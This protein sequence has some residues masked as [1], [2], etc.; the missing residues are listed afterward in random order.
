MNS[1]RWKRRACSEA[2]ILTVNPALYE[3]ALIPESDARLFVETHHYSASYPAARCRVGLYKARQ[4]WYGLPELV[5][6]AVFSV[7]CTQAVV[8][9]YAP[10]LA[11]NEGV[12]LGRFVLLD[13]EPAN[14]ETWFLARAFKLLKAALPQVRVIVSY[15]DPMPRVTLDGREVKPGHYGG[16]YH[17]SS[18]PALGRSSRRTLTLAPDATVIS[19]RGLSKIRLGEVGADYVERQL[20]RA[21]CPTRHAGE[22]GASYV[23]RVCAQLRKVKHPGNLVFGKALDRKVIFTVKVNQKRAVSRETAILIGASEG[24]GQA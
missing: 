21:G 19:E 6:V 9:C 15:S 18:M 24:L 23:T 11:P 7:P 3:V 22:S 16:I 13:E 10:D 2:P 4:A 20:V 5:G 17:A 1:Q 12:E 14:A 8:P